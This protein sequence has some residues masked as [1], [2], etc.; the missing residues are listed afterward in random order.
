MLGQPPSVTCIGGLLYLC[1]PTPRYTDSFC[2]FKHCHTRKFFENWRNPAKLTRVN[3][4]WRG[5]FKTT[6]GDFT[7]QHPEDNHDQSPKI[8]LSC[9]D[10]HVGRINK[11]TDAKTHVTFFLW[12]YMCEPGGF[13]PNQTDFSFIFVPTQSSQV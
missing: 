8:H 4:H 6:T 12:Q 13:Q 10:T 9:K 11:R 7:L 5:Q 3:S 2:T 1:L